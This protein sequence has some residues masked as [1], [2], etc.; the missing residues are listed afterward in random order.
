MV[1]DQRR[2]LALDALTGLSV[3]DA[4]GNQAFPSQWVVRSPGHADSWAW[5]DDTQMA[6]SLLEIVD[7]H[8]RVDQD[9][10]ARAFAMRADPFRDYGMGALQFID[11]VKHGGRWRE[12]TPQLFEG[13]G[14]WGNG[15]AMRVAP[16]GA[17]FY[18]D[19][20]RAAAE[21][22]ASSQ[23]THAHPEGVAGGIAVG[24]AAAHAAAH[25]G[26]PLSGAD[27]IAVALDH[28]PESMVRDGLRRAL[29][30][31]DRPTTQVAV[32]LGNGSRISAPDTVPF[33][34]WTIA[35]HLH[36]YEAA[37]R[38]CVEAGGDMDTMAAIVGGTI[39]AHQGPEPI[40]TEWLAAREPLPEWL[41][42]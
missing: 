16:L 38:T 8:G 37:I 36:D 2:G 34:L 9:A 23:V 20:Q 40:P 19:L 42:L 27:L 5:T 30:L 18:D 4:F 15:G 13:K 10:L 33:A 3:G 35:T 1:L 25:R 14:S 29:D 17:Y 12:I 41:P 21:A 7:T 31:L 22:A 6:C 28:T 26:R 39:A 11:H 24:V 32:E